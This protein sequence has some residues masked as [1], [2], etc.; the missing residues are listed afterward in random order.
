MPMIVCK[1]FLLLFMFS[2]TAPIVENS[3][4]LAGIYFI[5]LKNILNQLKSLLMISNL[6]LS[7][8]IGLL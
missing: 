2:L 4:I 3:H 1:N 8:K 6:D 7:E 5:F